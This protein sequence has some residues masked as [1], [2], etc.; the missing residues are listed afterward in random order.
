MSYAEFN[1]LSERNQTFVLLCALREGDR[2]AAL[3]EHVTDAPMEKLRSALAGL[4]K[5]PKAQLQEELWDPIVASTKAGGEQLFQF[6]EAGW[7]LENFKTEAP[8][9]LAWILD[10]V[11]KAKSGRVLSELPKETRKALKN[12][13]LKTLPPGVENF[14]RKRCQERFPKIP[15]EQVRGKGI[16][17]RLSEMKADLFLK[18]IRELGIGE[19]SIA[20]SKIDRAAT[21]AI[22]HR[23]NLQDAK[24]L[25]QRIKES[26]DFP[27]AMQ[28]E[29]QLNILGLDM[30]TISADELPYEIGF[31]VFSKAFSKEDVSVTPLFIYKLPQRQGYILKRYLDQNATANSNDAAAK[32]Q[33]R[34]SETFEQVLRK[35][36]E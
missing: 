34:V 18:L 29:A 33:E 20:F 11:P 36:E 31:A 19:M 24:E 9:I 21:R 10:R 17:D 6:A 1:N 35:F 28:R 30:D 27:L 23:L 8:R 13:K 2:A 16:F 15:L 5:V 25:R 22:L 26:G 14:L 3:L 12:I 7:I 32:M 4:Q